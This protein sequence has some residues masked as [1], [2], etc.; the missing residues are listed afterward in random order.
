MEWQKW[1]GYKVEQ[2]ISVVFSNVC[3]CLSYTSHCIGLLEIYVQNKLAL[4]V[5]TTEMA[6]V[7]SS[8]SSLC[9]YGILF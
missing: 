6:Y 1:V 9:P 2:V 5:H 3:T 4:V 8:I 7:L